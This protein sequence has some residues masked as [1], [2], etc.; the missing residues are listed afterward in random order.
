MYHY[1]PFAT[2]SVE[3]ELTR[4]SGTDAPTVALSYLVMLIYITVALSS[5]PPPGQWKQLFVLSRASLGVAGETCAGHMR[6][7]S[8]SVTTGNTPTSCTSGS[9]LPGD[10]VSSVSTLPATAV[11]SGL[12]LQY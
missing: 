2:R 1:F 6:P 11:L 3:D 8:C 5:L 9:A 10:A 12:A 7:T 4:E